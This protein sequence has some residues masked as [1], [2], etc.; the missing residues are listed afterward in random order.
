MVFRKTLLGERVERVQKNGPADFL[1][2]RVDGEKLLLVEIDT[3][4]RRRH[5]NTAQTRQLGCTFE[6]FHGELGRLHGHRTE[7]D[8]TFWVLNYDLGHLVVPEL[9]QL[10]A[11]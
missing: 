1:A 10:K 3:I 4:N 11:E 7:T 2:F 9:R 5:V 8:E 6:L